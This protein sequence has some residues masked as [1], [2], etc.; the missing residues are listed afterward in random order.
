[1]SG[2]RFSLTAICLVLA[3]SLA[4]HAQVKQDDSHAGQ[5]A[6]AGHAGQAGHAGSQGGS[7]VVD[8]DVPD[9]M[10]LD[11][12]GAPGRFVSDRI[13]DRLA[14]VSFTFTDCTTICPLLDGVFLG[15]QD[16]IAD[17]LGQGT[18][19]LTVSI[20][21]VRDIPERLKQHA[22]NLQAR[23]G[24]SFLTGEKQTVNSLLKALEVWASDIWNHPPTVFVVDGRR[25]V[26]TRLSG[27]PEPEKIVEVLDRYQTARSEREEDKP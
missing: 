20:D 26:W 8:F 13:G 6:H 2:R 25:H 1:M 24:W 10:L 11:Q 16:E 19:L 18:V 21:P 23:P 5:A 15:L 9:V 27:F 17:Q 4:L 7:N 14:A 12:E 3:L 22:A